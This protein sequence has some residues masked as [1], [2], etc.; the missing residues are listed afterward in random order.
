MIGVDVGVAEVDGVHARPT[1]APKPAL[2]VALV[3]SRR[4][5]P[6]LSGCGRAAGRSAAVSVAAAAATAATKR[7]WSTKPAER[8]TQLEQS[9]WA[10][11]PP[12]EQGTATDV[13][14][15]RRGCGCGTFSGGIEAVE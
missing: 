14:R 7:F 12:D 13:V 4:P 1:L 11:E 6:A 15:I 3:G 5:N 10:R 2:E 8:A 9:A